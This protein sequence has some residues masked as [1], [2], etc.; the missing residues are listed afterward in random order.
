MKTRITLSILFITML[1]SLGY[2]FAFTVF[3]E[4]VKINSVAKCEL[5]T[6]MNR[7]WGDQ[8]TWTRH[9]VFNAI[10]DLPGTNFAIDRLFR[11]Q[12][13]ISKIIKPYYGSYTEEK[14]ANLL[15]ISAIQR[16]EM[17]KA[18]KI[19]SPINKKD[20]DRINTKWKR[21]AD[22]IATL[23]CELNPYWKL[24]IMKKMFQDQI[25]Q[26][27]VMAI[28]RRNK[29]YSDDMNYYEKLLKETLK[30]SDT[31]TLGI[32]KHFPDRFEGVIKN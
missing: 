1:L 9:I 26:I 27:T 23:L 20:L 13:E 28:A 22:D 21:N 18:V 7:L 16:M 14:L 32:I 15:R 6:K 11:T 3:E 19:S 24:D 2:N 29:Y 5:K 4:K 31:L 30:L 17:F 10:D 25:S 8:V 12:N